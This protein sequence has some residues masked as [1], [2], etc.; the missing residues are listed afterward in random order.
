MALFHKKERTGKW[1]IDHSLSIALFT[2]LVVFTA[3]S[4]AAGY[5]IWQAEEIPVAFLIWFAHAW[6]TSTLADAFGVFMVV[7]LSKWLFERGSN[8][9]ND[10]AELKEKVPEEKGN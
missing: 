3:I 5:Q 9:D 6:F 4:M 8:E 10:N 1:W 2:I 7:M